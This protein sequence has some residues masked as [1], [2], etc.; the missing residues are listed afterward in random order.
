[1]SVTI[2]DSFVHLHS[3]NVLENLLKEVRVTQSYIDQIFLQLFTQTQFL[4][5]YKDYKVPV[6]ALAKASISKWIARASLP[7]HIKTLIKAQKDNDLLDEDEPED[8]V[9]IETKSRKRRPKKIDVSHEMDDKYV[10][11]LDVLPPLPEKGRFDIQVVKDSP[12]F[13]S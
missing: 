11:L 2:R 9:S 1:M 8:D 5:R 4:E 12:Y 13:F 7:E 10:N 3:S 6:E